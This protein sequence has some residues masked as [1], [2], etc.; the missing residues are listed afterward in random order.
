MKTSALAGAALFVGMLAL[1]VV[2]VVLGPFVTIWALNTLFPSLAIPLNFTTWVATAWF[3][4]V[5][6][7]RV[8]V[9]K[10]K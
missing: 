8:T 9:Q 3:H 2:F 4:L 10:S 7:Q 5:L 6:S 1:I